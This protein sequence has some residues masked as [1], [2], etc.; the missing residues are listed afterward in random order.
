MNQSQRMSPLR[1][2]C[3]AIPKA[4]KGKRGQV[5]T[6]PIS[7]WPR[8]LHNQSGGDMRDYVTATLLVV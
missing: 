4:A 3:S 5:G 7:V 2:G 6:A 8:I 1:A